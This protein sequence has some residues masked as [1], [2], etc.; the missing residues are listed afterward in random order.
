[1]RLFVAV[2][3]NTET[4]N[5]WELTPFRAVD[6]ISYRIYNESVAWLCPVGKRT[7]PIP[8]RFGRA[9]GEGSGKERLTSALA[10]ALSPRRGRIVRRLIEKPATGLARRSSAK[11]ET[12]ESY[13]LSWGRG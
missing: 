13:F 11:P 5:L 4:A 3:G 6:N 10:P 8:G 9:A 1:M 2:L 7:D 12:T